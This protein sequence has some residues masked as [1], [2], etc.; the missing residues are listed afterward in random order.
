MSSNHNEIVNK[1]HNVFINLSAITPKG[2]FFLRLLVDKHQDDVLYSSTS[3]PVCKIQGVSISIQLSHS[4][5]KRPRNRNQEEFR[6]EVID[7]LMS[8]IVYKSPI[9]NVM[10]TLAFVDGGICIKPADADHSRIIKQTELE[11]DYFKIVKHLHCKSPVLINNS[12]FSVMRK[13]YSNELIELI[14]IEQLQ[15]NGGSLISPLYRIEMT[16][17]ILYAYKNEVLNSGIVHCDIKHENIRIHV[18]Y[19]TKPRASMIDFDDYVKIDSKVGENLVGTTNYYPPEAL[20]KGA[21]ITETYD[22]FSIARILAHLWHSHDENLYLYDK[23]EYQ[24][25]LKDNQFIL[26]RLF[27]GIPFLPEDIKNSISHILN[28]MHKREP[29]DRLTIDDAILEFE[30]VKERYLEKNI[31]NEKELEDKEL[32]YSSAAK[33]TVLFP[34]STNQSNNEGL[35]GKL[36]NN[37]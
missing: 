8:D 25:Y 16:L 17:A 1:K 2:A 10:A 11:P 15:L 9:F 3:Y 35:C 22:I 5:L 33:F 24:E 36:A 14:N 21:I 4:M 32:P 27:H 12:F 26:E 37:F 29:H 31:S 19:V 13:V 28:E 34:P 20:E 23:K 30:Q 7:G 18:N 6:Y